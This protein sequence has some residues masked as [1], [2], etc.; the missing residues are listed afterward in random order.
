MLREAMS[1]DEVTIEFEREMIFFLNIHY[2]VKLGINCF[3]CCL[4]CY[5]LYLLELNLLEF[6]NMKT[7]YY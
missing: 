6:Q 5:L 1:H 7:K 2:I 3:E 4:N